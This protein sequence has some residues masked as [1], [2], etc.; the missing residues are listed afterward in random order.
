MSP[1]SARPRRSTGSSPSTRCTTRP[2][3]TAVLAGIAQAL[4]PDGIYFC[5]DVSASSHVHENIDHPLGPALYT[6]S[7]IC[8]RS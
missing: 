6:V 5:V 3:P 1:R 7:T 4:R 8:R 2:T